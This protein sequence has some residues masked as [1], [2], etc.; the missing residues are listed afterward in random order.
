MPE[1]F[2]F[3]FEV[4]YNHCMY[5]GVVLLYSLAYKLYTLRKLHGRN[6]TLVPM[7]SALNSLCMST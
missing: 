2:R 3:L 1:L 4:Q 6:S 7:Y 5:D